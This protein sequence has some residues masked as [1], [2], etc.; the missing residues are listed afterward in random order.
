[1]T[2]VT[3]VCL[4]IFSLRIL[5]LSEI[6]HIAHTTRQARRFKMLQPPKVTMEMSSFKK[7]PQVSRVENSESHT[8]TS[9]S[10][11]DSGGGKNSISTWK[12]PEQIR[13]LHVATY[14]AR[15]LRTENRGTRKRS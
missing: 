12:K 9:V 15:T 10:L 2:S 7:L 11:A 5:S 13:E 3:P 6:P 1:M 4:L 14:N 8:D